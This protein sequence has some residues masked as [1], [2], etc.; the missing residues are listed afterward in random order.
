MGI[1]GVFC[2]VGSSRGITS[3]VTS[4]VAVREPCEKKGVG[5]VQLVDNSGHA[6][7]ANRVPSKFVE[8]DE[9]LSVSRHG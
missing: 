7:A 4:D 3:V 2:G 9:F 1:D 5:K 8:V 6:G